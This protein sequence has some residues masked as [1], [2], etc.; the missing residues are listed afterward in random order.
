[1]R[2]G[3]AVFLLSFLVSIWNRQVLK[4]KIQDCILEIRRS[5]RK[6]HIPFGGDD[7]IKCVD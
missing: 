2:I 4:K 5:K 6:R 3:V 1:M 7:F